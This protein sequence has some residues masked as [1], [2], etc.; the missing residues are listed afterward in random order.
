MLLEQVQELNGYETFKE[1]LYGA[2]RTAFHHQIKGQTI[3]S[4][5]PYGEICVHLQW[6]DEKT[7]GYAV[8]GVVFNSWSDRKEQLIA[9]VKRLAAAQFFKALSDLGLT[10]E[11]GGTVNLKEGT[12][13]PGEG[14]RIIDKD[15]REQPQP[16]PQ[17]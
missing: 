5:G 9:E 13:V 2:L 6:K 10:A 17:Q 1:S 7:V 14:I 8:D 3:K 12:I 11:K 4:V 16:K 15:G